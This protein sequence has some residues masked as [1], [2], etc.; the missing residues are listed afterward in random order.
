MLRADEVA[1]ALVAHWLSIHFY[2]KVIRLRN[3]NH[4]I[5]HTV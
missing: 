4:Y 1:L 3:T 2:V 5:C